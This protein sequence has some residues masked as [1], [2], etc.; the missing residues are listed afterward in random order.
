MFGSGKDGVF[1][2]GK[3]KK[4][5]FKWIKKRTAW[6]PMLPLFNKQEVEPFDSEYIYPGNQVYA[7]CLNGEWIPG[8]VNIDKDE[9]TIRAEINPVPYYVRNWQSLQHKKNAQEFLRLPH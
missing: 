7:F 6:K 2:I 4:N 8:R 9:D 5:R 1:S 3:K